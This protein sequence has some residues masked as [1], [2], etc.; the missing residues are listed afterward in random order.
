MGPLAA[1]GAADLGEAAGGDMPARVVR[2]EINESASLSRVSLEADLTFRALIVAVDDYGRLDARPEILKA[3]LFP[4]RKVTEKRLTGWVQE[5]ADE[6]CVL[7][8]EVSERPYLYLTGWEHHRGSGRR[9][10]ESRCPPPS[11]TPSPASEKSEKCAEI[12][13]RSER[14]ETRSERRE[15]GASAPPA[16]ASGFLVSAERCRKRFVHHLITSDPKH[17]V[18]RKTSFTGWDRDFERLLRIDQCGEPEVASMMEWVFGHD[19][20]A[21]VIQSPAKLREKWD[22]LK[23]QRKRDQHPRASPAQARIER[24]KLAAAQVV[25]ELEGRQ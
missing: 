12:L 22:T 15:S 1:A 25:A 23:G 3:K 4:V 8:Y 6:G 2:G 7:L 13:P 21:P 5:L 16:A 19:F 11:D 18:T 14:R 17:S 9:A 24:G 20:W 10:K